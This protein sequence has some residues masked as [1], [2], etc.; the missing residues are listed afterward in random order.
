M[1]IDDQKDLVELFS[2]P[3]TYGL[4]GQS[5]EK[6]ETHISRVFLAGDRA[7][8]TKRAVKLPYVDF[9]TPR[10]R[11]AACERELELNSPSAAGLYLAVRRITRRPDGGLEFD[12]PGELR[13]AAVEMRRFDQECMFDRM[14]EAGRL[15]PALMTETANAIARYHAAAPAVAGSGAANMAAVLDINEAGF[16]TSRV[17]RE[18]ELRPLFVAFRSTHARLSAHLDRRAADGKVR[19]CHGDLHLRNICLIDGRPCLFD[20]IEFNDAIATTDVLY[21]LAYLLMDLWHRGHGDFANLVVN[22]Y[23]DETGDDDG[24]VLLP[25]FM[26]VRA[27]VR[28]H[29]LATQADEAAGD[30]A[31]EAVSKSYFQLAGE[32][33]RAAEPVL[34]AIGGLSGSGKSTVAEALAPRIGAPP[35]ARIFESDRLRKAMHNVRPETELPDAAYAPEISDKVYGELVRR[36][37]AIVS[38]NGTVIADAVFDRAEARRRIAE[39]ARKSGVR[40][41]G[42]WLDCD[43]AILRQRVVEREKGASDADIKVLEAQLARDL[44]PMEWTVF[45][46]AL[47]VSQLVETI[48]A[49]VGRANERR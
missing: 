47:P 22:R 13:D 20:C 9:S 36:A 35:G 33:L 18:P 34:I 25:F 43:P 32:L 19:R 17:Y 42:F 46:S 5:I 44:G 29:V 3:A 27:E 23:L 11:L 48:A 8:K 28:A 37:V 2:D 10:L 12:G 4:T 49:T 6:I 45:D 26:A 16:R 38:A 31:L 21:D 40:F 30:A 7:Y 14:A 39:A 1:I 41:A 24:F 15:T